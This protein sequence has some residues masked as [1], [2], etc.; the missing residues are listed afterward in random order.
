MIVGTGTH[1]AE[2][3]A[4]LTSFAVHSGKSVVAKERSGP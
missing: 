3:A 4:Q 2:A 1:F